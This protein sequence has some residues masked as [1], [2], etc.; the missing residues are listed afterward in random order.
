MTDLDALLAG[1]VA[2]PHEPVR[3]L[4][5]ADWLDDHG[6]ADRAELLRLHRMMIDT[7]C[8]PDA[9]PDRAAWQAR[10]VELIDQGVKPC[11]PQHTLKLPGG[12]PLVGNFIPPGSFLMG[13]EVEESEKP[14]HK[15]TIT[16]GFFIGIHIVT[17][18]QWRAVMDTDIFIPPP[19]AVGDDLPMPC[20]SWDNATKYCKGLTKHSKTLT[21]EP[22]SVVRL[23]TEAEWEYACRAGT[24]THFHWGD[25]PTAR[26]MKYNTESSWNGSAKKRTRG[27][28]T[29]VGSFAANPWGLYDCHGNLNEWCRDWNDEGYYS[30]AAKR[31]PECKGSDYLDKVIRG[32]CWRAGPA[33]CR[34]AS[35]NGEMPPRGTFDVGFRV[36]FTLD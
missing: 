23:P 30:R 18:A 34:A 26:R 6:F 4:I 19:L 12:V 10:I 27:G 7:C 24:T 28:I 35:R 29:A 11:V 14:V 36:V 32:G 3:W 33:M 25:V 16:K 2:H 9:H 17:Q 21:T 5:V 13:S 20:V 31:N 1:I 15:A 8:E 22:A